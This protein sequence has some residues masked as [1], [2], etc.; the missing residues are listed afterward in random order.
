ME[1]FWITVWAVL[2][3]GILWASWIDYS[4]RRVPNWLNAT[5]L[6]AGFVAQGIFN[7]W[8][9]CRRRSGACSW[10]SAS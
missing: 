5:L 4:Q 10:D 1:P 9:G 3:P 6:V 7:G 2:V 8:G